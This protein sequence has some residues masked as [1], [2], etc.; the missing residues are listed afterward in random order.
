[1]NI[2]TPSTYQYDHDDGYWIWK[3]RY[4]NI[5]RMKYH[6][7]YPEFIVYGIKE[8]FDEN[9]IFNWM[10]D[11]LDLFVGKWCIDYFHNLV[12]F[13]KYEDALLLSMS[14]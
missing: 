2:L 1:M 8:V 10:Q 4:D 6:G 9:T 14:N 3:T 5:E 11:N 13:E 7:I 12:A